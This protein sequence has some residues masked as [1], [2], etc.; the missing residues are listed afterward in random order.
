M[1]LT[2]LRFGGY[3]RLNAP[4]AQR[5]VPVL[6]E[7]AQFL[8]EALGEKIAITPSKGRDTDV[9]ALV[10]GGGEG[11]DCF[12]LSQFNG[13]AEKVLTPKPAP[14]QHWPSPEMMQYCQYRTEADLRRSE[15]HYLQTATYFNTPFY[16]VAV[17]RNGDTHPLKIHRD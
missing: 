11:L 15:Q 13:T 7:A 6:Q 4:T 10:C 2:T 8:A 17:Q 3:A 12:Y 9:V 16:T 5:Q 14:L 1:S